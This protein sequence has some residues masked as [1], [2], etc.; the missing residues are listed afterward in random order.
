MVSLNDPHKLPRLNRRWRA[1]L[2]DHVIG[3]AWH[4]ASKSLAAAAVSGPVHFLSAEDGKPTHQLPGHAFGTASLAFKPDGSLLATAGQDGKAR[5]WDAATGKEAAALDAGAAWAEV[6]SWHPTQDVLATAAGKKVRLWDS[7]GTMLRELPP[8]PA[9]VAALAW[10]P[11]TN[12]LTTAG[13]GAIRVWQLDR[14]APTHDLPWNNP[15]LALAWRPDGS[16]LAHGDRDGSAHLWLLAQGDHLEMSGYPSKVR[17]VCWLADRFLLT[18]GADVVTMWDCKPPGPAGTQPGALKGH[19]GLVTALALAPA[20]LAS[21]GEDGK[22][23]LW[24]PGGQR[25]SIA[26]SEA[27]AEVSALAWSPSGRLLAVGNAVGGVSLYS[28]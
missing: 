13:Y 2:P 15:V 14:E 25:K 20:A 9:T 18:D 28:V 16:A 6:V 1:T 17:N 11:R 4:P 27:G 21:G 5:L 23:M 12:E 7:A 19:K 22:V 26:A 24:A 8:Q 3:L 10:R